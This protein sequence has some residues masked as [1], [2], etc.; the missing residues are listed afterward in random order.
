MKG[1]TLNA[2]T[3]DERIARKAERTTANRIVIH[4]LTASVRS[5]RAR[6]R[7]DAL[8]AHACA[9]L[10]A[11]RTDHALWPAV[12]CAA[13]V[14]RQAS[15]HGVTVNS[16]ALA[17]CTAWRRVARID[18]W[19]VFL[20]AG[21]FRAIERSCKMDRWMDRKEIRNVNDDAS[22]ESYPYSSVRGTRPADRRRNRSDTRTSARARKRCT[23]HSDR[24]RPDTGRDTCCSRTRDHERNRCS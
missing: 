8:L 5:A 11:G 12:G 9:I 6:T 17:V 10:F 4:R 21:V 14:A 22:K 18:G 3:I 24:R 16:T 23:R 1:L 13:N 19:F 20:C 15:A 7:I 2:P